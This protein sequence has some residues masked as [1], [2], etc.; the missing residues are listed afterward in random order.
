MSAGAVWGWVI[1]AAGGMRWDRVKW[2][3][4]R[5]IFKRSE[6]ISSSKRI[7]QRLNRLY[8]DSVVL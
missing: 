4:D 3:R 6:P 8:M 7:Q 1:S 2:D 5:R